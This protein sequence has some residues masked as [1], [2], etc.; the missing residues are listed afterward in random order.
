[1][2]E[3]LVW[4][5]KA[6]AAISGYAVAVL[7]LVLLVLSG[8]G[9]LTGDRIRAAFDALRGKTPAAA[10][11]VEKKPAEDLSERE[12]I[13]EKRS[14]ELQTVEERAGLRLSLI[15]AEQEALDRKRA[16][17]QTVVTEAH[18]VQQDASDS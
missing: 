14:R 10:V 7:G 8:S 5:L 15:K 6:Y 1:M 18:R 13:L 9:A 16:E 2:K 11:V 4:L 17:A 3:F 12:Q